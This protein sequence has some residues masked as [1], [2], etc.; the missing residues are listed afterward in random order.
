M[1][2]ITWPNDGPDNH[3]KINLILKLKQQQKKST[4]PE[5][6]GSV[7]ASR[8][9][10]PPHLLP[11]RLVQECQLMPIWLQLE[12]HGKRWAA[13]KSRCGTS[14]RSICS[15]TEAEAG[16]V[17]CDILIF[18][19]SWC[20]KAPSHAAASLAPSGS[21]TWLAVWVPATLWSTLLIC[22]G[23]FIDLW[24]SLFVTFD[25]FL[26]CALKKKS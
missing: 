1:S 5:P 14:K 22:L 19:H 8:C 6:L 10:S 15:V 13:G 26:K 25:F 12:H 18:C 7:S 20:L 21:F 17:F 3:N 16:C 4:P 23:L 24:R 9:V 11:V 2:T